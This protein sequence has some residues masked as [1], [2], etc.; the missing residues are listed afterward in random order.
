MTL[1]GAGNRIHLIPES[2]NVTIRWFILKV[3]NE[4]FSVGCILGEMNITDEKEI[5]FFV[6]RLQMNVFSG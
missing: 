2:D 4:E 6:D 3:F 1:I 5:D